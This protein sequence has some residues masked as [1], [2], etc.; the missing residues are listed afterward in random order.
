MAVVAPHMSRT[1]PTRRATD[2][3]VLITPCSRSLLT[4]PELYRKQCSPSNIRLIG[5]IRPYKHLHWGKKCQLHTPHLHGVRPKAELTNPILHRLT[6]KQEN[7]T[8]KRQSQC[9]KEPKIAQIFALPTRSQTSHQVQ[10][11]NLQT[12]HLTNKPPPKCVS[13]TPTQTA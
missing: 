12:T 11:H 7:H 10:S 3:T 13:P 1:E 6:L 9:K 4:R 8:N 5:N 2:T